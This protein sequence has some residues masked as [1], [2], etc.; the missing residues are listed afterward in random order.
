MLD[1]QDVSGKETFGHSRFYVV[2]LW[3]VAVFLAT[4]LSYNFEDGSVRTVT[5]SYRAGAERWLKGESMY[6]ATIV[7]GHVVIYPPQ[8]YI[9]S[10][11]FVLSEGFLVELIW[12]AVSVGLWGYAIV[13]LARF[14]EPSFGRPMTFA[15][16]LVVLL[17]S[18]AAARIGQY[19]LPVAASMILLSIALVQK[20]WN[21]AT[22]WMLLGMFIKPFFIPFYCLTFVLFGPMRLRLL[23]AAVFYGLFPFLWRSP[24]YVL[25]QYADYPAALKRVGEIGFN[26]HFASL[27]MPIKLLNIP[28]T[29]QAWTVLQ[30]LAALTVLFLCYRLLRR[31]RSPAYTALWYYSLPCFYLV[32]MNPR[33]ENNGYAVL[34]PL[35]VAY[36]FME[37]RLAKN[38]PLFAFL[39][40]LIVGFIGHYELGKM[41][42]DKDLV[43]IV[44]P[45]L[46]LMF[47][48]YLC[49]RARMFCRF[50]EG[51]PHEN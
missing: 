47:I 6:A 30:A 50:E 17:L 5:N 29:P 14:L 40:C 27:L 7:D 44:C 39:V 43:T 20:R 31:D 1:P 19:T 33:T 32:L 34:A 26:E 48:V 21:A 25:K 15:Y 41:L 45:V 38:I 10:I 13:R 11:P 37:F 12:R 46:A 49:F 18:M 36:T 42:I 28:M 35:L 16:S 4:L 8:S 22:S 3:V 23:L 24:D 51:K 2:V 9:V